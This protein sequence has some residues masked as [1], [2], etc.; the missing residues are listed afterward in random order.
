MVD[1]PLLIDID[2]PPGAVAGDDGHAQV[3][4]AEQLP[5]AQLGRVA[6][7]AED[8]SLKDKVSLGEGRGEE[9]GVHTHVHVCGILHVYKTLAKRL[10]KQRK[11][12]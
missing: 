8:A 1:L 5:L 2:P 12:C 10:K 6:G 7:T 3:S 11:Q 4:A 9:R